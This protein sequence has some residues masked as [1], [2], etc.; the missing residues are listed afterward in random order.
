M[1]EQP[2]VPVLIVS[3]FLG[4]GKTTL[5]RHLLAEAQRTG[6]RLAILSNEFGDTGIDRALLDAG[7]DG[8][9]EL[10]GG[11]VCCRLSDAVPDTV[12]RLLD[13][14][15]PDRLVVETSGVAHPGELLIQFWRPPLDTL[16]HNPT[17][18][19]VVDALT[20]DKHRYDP[21]FESQIEA[22]DVLVLT[23]VDRASAAATDRATVGLK[24]A[25]GRPVLHAIAGNVD[26]QEL[27]PPGRPTAPPSKRHSHAQYGTATL[28]FPVD[29]PIDEVF[30]AIRARQPLRAKGFV[31]V[32][33]TILVV[34]GVGDDLAVEAPRRAPPP[35]LVGLVVVITATP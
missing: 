33:G 9:V 6:H 34:Q 13:A 15:R 1:P 18:V 10:D 35:E 11:C 31:S 32:A 27:W 3:G 7:D 25:T 29:T 24:D 21:T 8:I 16:T 19:V 2:P 28:Q 30:A 5:V 14:A 12:Q 20:F 26:V 17:V 22:A 23:K 4:A